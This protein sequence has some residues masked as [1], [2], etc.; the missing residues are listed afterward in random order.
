MIDLSK[1]KY[2]FLDVDG[3][4]SIPQYRDDNGNMRIGG[5][6]DWWYKYNVGKTDTYKNCIVPDKM[7]EFIFRLKKNNI[8][9]YVLTAVS[10]VDEYFN[11]V[12]F[13]LDNYGVFFH[14]YRDILF[15]HTDSEKIKYLCTFAENLDIP[16]KEILIVDDTLGILLQAETDGFSAM[17]VSEILG[18]NRYV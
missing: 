16:R 4:L 12:D 11:K 3:V 1:M 18:T 15:V 10:C 5:T 7:K 14:S 13:V 8:Q 9:T 6:E 2:A 17:H